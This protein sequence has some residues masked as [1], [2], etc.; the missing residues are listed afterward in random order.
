MDRNG[1]GF[2][3]D[4]SELF[5]NGTA[6]PRP[7]GGEMKNG[8]RALAVFDRRDQGGNENGL[9]DRGDTVFPRLRVWQDLDHDEMS[10]A[11]E[12]VRLLDAGVCALDLLYVTSQRTDEHGNVFYYR[13]R[14]WDCTGQ[15]RRWT[16]DVFLKA[17]PEP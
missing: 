14:V 8:F 7:T 17:R 2:I 5:G 15:Q 6:Q 10:E 11:N 9:I 16:W 13:G 4:G 12:L 1:N 3:D